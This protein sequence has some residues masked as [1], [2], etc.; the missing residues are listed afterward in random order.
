ME[1]DVDIRDIVV[2]FGLWIVVSSVYDTELG[3]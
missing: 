3:L 2:P 1:L